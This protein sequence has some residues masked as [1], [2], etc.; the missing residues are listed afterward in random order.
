M[1]PN[2]SA[3][4]AT[5]NADYQASTPVDRAVVEV[6][7]ASIETYQGNPH[8]SDH[9]L[10]WKAM[11]S[12]E[13]SKVIISKELGCTPDSIVFT[14]GATEANNLAILGLAARATSARRRI[15]VSPTEHKCVLAAASLAARRYGCEVE[16][17]AVDAAGHVVLEELERRL[18]DDVLLVSAM[19]VHNEIGT[20]A[21]VARL[22]AL[23]ASAGAIFHC[24][25]A[26]AL[27]AMPLD[28]ADLDI[29]MLSLSGHKIYGPKGIGA[30]IVRPEIQE[31]LEPLIVGGGQQNGLRSGTLPVALCAAL[32]E[33]VRLLGGETAAAERAR[34]RR[35]RDYF[36]T[37]LLEDERVTLN[38]PPLEQRHPG[39]C[40]L[41]FSGWDAQDLLMRLQP[42]LA[43]S[44]GS[45]C[46]SGAPEPSYVLRA[47]GLS[48][49]EAA[50][51]IRF[52][53][54][55]FSTEADIGTAVSAVREAMT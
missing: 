46:T 24:D 11:E 16:H 33:A 5:I 29:G 4:T 13:S 18:G 43:A 39:N 51:S 44:T 55:R 35:L 30:L 28:L 34:V 22:S 37:A 8:A 12:V 7:I 36:A 14:S 52:S 49:D 48:V 38:G 31:E 40:N 15:L 23:C 6:L 10:G 1:I 42:R 9:V 53:F 25:G 20:I 2:L 50:S 45:A 47:I 19:A 21:P 41:R 27:P 54:G 3:M 17:L 32:A 26:Q